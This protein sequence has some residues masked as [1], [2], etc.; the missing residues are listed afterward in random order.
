MICGQRT[1]NY[2]KHFGKG[3][4][5]SL[6]NPALK[7]S[8]K[9]QLRKSQLYDTQVFRQLKQE[10]RA[11]PGC[12][13]MCLCLHSAT[14]ETPVLSVTGIERHLNLCFAKLSLVWEIQNQL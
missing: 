2:L 11:V 4:V 6:P 8:Y 14:A 10:I 5:C 9:V 13:N 3:I 1:E 7:K 12:S